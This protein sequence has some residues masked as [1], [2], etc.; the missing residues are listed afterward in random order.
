MP[1]HGKPLFL[2]GIAK[3]HEQNVRPCSFNPAENVL[4]VHLVEWLELW[5][6]ATYYA[7]A[8]VL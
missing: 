4:M 7:R 3:G 8:R 5:R 2:F 1:M 6:I